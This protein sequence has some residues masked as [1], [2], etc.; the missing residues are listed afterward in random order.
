M[1]RE[2]QGDR[3]TNCTDDAKCNDC[4]PPVEV[5]SGIW[6]ANRCEEHRIEAFTL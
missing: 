6:M 5:K 2:T 1:S 4:S 3:I